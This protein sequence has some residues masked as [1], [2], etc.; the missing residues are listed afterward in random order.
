[1]VLGGGTGSIGYLRVRRDGGGRSVVMFCV[2]SR[3]V[4]SII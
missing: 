4:K 1:M 3:Y 2:I